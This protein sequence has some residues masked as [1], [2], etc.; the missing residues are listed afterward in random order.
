MKKFVDLQCPSCGKQFIDV[1]CVP[2]TYPNCDVCPPDDLLGGPH[3]IRLFLPTSSPTIH[4]D[5]IPG[6]IEIKHGI[7]HAD[8]TPKKYYSHSEI[9]K[10][11]KAKGYVNQPERGV[12]DKK[13]WDKLSRST[14]EAH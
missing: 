6:G 5:S 4:G 14:R 10:A 3:L 9:H 7:C 11:A 8:G 13:V 1:F 12:A 2:P